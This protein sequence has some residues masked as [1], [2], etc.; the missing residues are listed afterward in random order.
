GRALFPPLAL[1]VA[2]AMIASYLLSST[3]VP[4]LAVWLFR[5]RTRA[6]AAA[7]PPFG[8]FGDA[9]ARLSAGLVRWRWLL[10]PAY[11]AATLPVLLV[12]TRLGTELSPRVDTG[13]F[14][15]RIR[16]PAGTRLERTE[17]IVREVDTA[18]RQEVG[19][20]LVAMTLA[21]IGNPPWSY[22]VN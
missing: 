19:E 6:P 1:A 15:M 22:P 4:V 11:V 7:G 16:A 20:G 9:Y 3:L 18:I 12:A 13:K 10:L 8:R 2:F 17:E 5:G 14:Q 21:N